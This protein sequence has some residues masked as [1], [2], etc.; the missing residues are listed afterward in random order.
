MEKRSGRENLFKKG[1]KRLTRGTVEGCRGITLSSTVV[2][3]TFCEILKD[4]MGTMMGEGR[5]SRRRTSRVQARP[6]LRRPC[7]HVRYD[8]PRYQVGKTRDL[9]RNVSLLVYRR[10][11]TSVEKWIVEKAVG[12]R[13]QRGNVE[14][15]E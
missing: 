2:G 14:N 13:D 6:W 9:E 7:A 8:N 12:N 15:G 10:P 11:T 4:R 5:Q 1:D 3:N